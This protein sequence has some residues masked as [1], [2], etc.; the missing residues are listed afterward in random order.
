ME[1]QSKRWPAV[2]A[3]SLMPWVPLAGL[4]ISLGATSGCRGGVFDYES[5]GAS[6]SFKTGADFEEWKMRHAVEDYHF[7]RSF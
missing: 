1:R 7:F 2:T 6:D 4:L 3:R 5:S